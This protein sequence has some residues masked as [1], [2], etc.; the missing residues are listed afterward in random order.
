MAAGSGRYSILGGQTQVQPAS[1][2]PT[3]TMSRNGVQV[4]HGFSVTVLSQT[5]RHGAQRDENSEGQ[6]LVGPISDRV[7]IENPFAVSAHAR[8]THAA[9]ARWLT[10]YFVKTTAD[11]LL[12]KTPSTPVTSR[13]ASP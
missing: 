8:V 6:V 7:R 10:G 11:A 13:K 4:H 9:V 2:A 3:A 5:N 1:D 12:L